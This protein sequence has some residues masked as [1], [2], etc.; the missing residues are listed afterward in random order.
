MK[1]PSS[2]SRHELAVAPKQQM[3]G[4]ALGPKDKSSHNKN[5]KGACREIDNRSCRYRRHAGVQLTR[6]G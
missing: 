4:P 6:R 5:Q 2:C 1:F 3:I